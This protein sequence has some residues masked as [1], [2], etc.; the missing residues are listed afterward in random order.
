MK[1]ILHLILIS[2]LGVS[3]GQEMNK[4]MLINCVPIHKEILWMS[5]TEVSNVQYEEYLYYL[6]N[7]TNEEDYLSA[8]QDTNI[9]LNKPYNPKYANYYHIHPAYKDYPVVGLTKEQAKAYCE[10]LTTIL[11]QN[12]TTELK[13]PVKEVVVRLPTEKEWKTAAQAG[14][15]SAIFGW[16]GN[17]PR[18]TLKKFEGQL[19]GNFIR[20]KGDFMGVAGSINDGADVTA[21]VQSYWPNKF[22]LY[23]M[24]G[25]VSELLLDSDKA[26]GGSWKTY[27][28]ALEIE[29]NAKFREDAK[30]SSSV[31]FRY[32]VEIISFK[33]FEK[34]EET[35]TSKMIENL[36]VNI[37][38]SLMVS[39]TEVTNQLYTF[40]VN[41]NK[42]KASKNN[43]WKTVAVYSDHLINNY[44]SHS[45]YSNYPV[46][47]IS[48]EDAQEF[49]VWL[50]ETYRKFEKR[51][52]DNLIFTLPTAEQ[53][54]KAARGTLK[55]SAYPWGGPYIRNVKGNLLANF[56]PVDERFEYFLEN[57]PD[58]SQNINS[59][60]Y[61]Q[62][63]LDGFQF[64]CNVETFN[65][66]DLGIYNAAGNVNEMVKEK[67]CKGGSWL[68]YSKAL[69]ITSEEKYLGAQPFTGFRFVAIKYQ[70]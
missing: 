52:F 58:I 24:S 17:T 12:Y 16:E 39:K 56:H 28:P 69:Q 50:T 26:I 4:A 31:G 35:L 57:D 49:C 27:L 40:F 20:G 25:N 9:W 3:F 47:N 46:V 62:K 13:H 2:Y 43:N 10:W 42:N 54:E 14:N 70:P 33:D 7:N 41:E 29:A 60:Y 11:N 45:Y 19:K 64:T 59:T 23:N 38:D 66:N 30:P 6:K 34:K 65:P 55:Q 8:I 44:A 63:E 67:V 53:W 36:L 22:G 1:Y 68:S 37:D 61:S 32:V 5:K 15:P 18:S 21:P 48:Y 51:K